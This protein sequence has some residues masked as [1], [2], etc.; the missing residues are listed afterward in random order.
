MPSHTD[1]TMKRVKARGSLIALVF[2][3]GFL[4]I[5]LQAVSLQVFKQ[6]GL[7]RKAEVRFGRSDTVTGKRGTI[8]DRH[9]RPLAVSIA[10]KAIGVYPRKAA[11]IKNVP[12]AARQIASL[13][14]ID[15]RKVERALQHPKYNWIKRPVPP[16]MGAAVAALKIPGVEVHPFH[17]RV[18]PSME[19]AGQ[20]IGASK[21]DD[22]GGR[23]GLEYRYNDILSPTTANRTVKWDGN[24]NPVDVSS[25]PLDEIS[26]SNLVLTIDANIQDIAESALK[27][28]AVTHK[29]SS[30][31]AVVMR[32]KTGEILAMAN[33]P[34]FNPNNFG[35]FSGET[36][37]NRAVAAGF[38][39]GSTMKVF[40]VAS[41]LDS[42][43][44]KQSSIFYCENGAYDIGGFTF[45]D[46]HEYEWLTLEQVIKFSSNIAVVKI[47]EIIG[48]KALHNALKDFGFGQRSGINLN[49]ESK[50]ILT[51]PSNWNMVETGAIAFGQGV[52]VT[53]LQLAT[54][55][56][57][58]ANDGMLV[59]P[60]IVKEVVS[61][62]GEREKTFSS[63]GEKRVISPETARFVKK[64]MAS[65]TEEG[66]TGVRA[67][68]S[69]YTV[70]GKTGTAQKI[71]P[72]KRYFKDRYIASFAGFVPMN[73]PE[74]SI[75]VV[76]DDPRSGGYYG[77]TVAGPAF[78][79][80]AYKTLD[81][82]H[83]A[84][85]NESI[86]EKLLLALKSEEKK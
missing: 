48:K 20:L 80:I 56:S 53:A 36:R 33:Y 73:N 52:S 70:C 55:Y 62:N 81:Y 15:A 34:G 28:A 4:V 32:P 26:G 46:T 50:G 24:G 76:L 6:G 64:I 54:A 10:A 22:I 58:L 30:G 84:P 23:N 13:L 74:L 61:P 41:A 29:A 79:E 3:M 68:L 72:N 78:R 35:A 18:Y 49:G 1:N 45:H 57:A 27:E 25:A 66:G 12:K 19:L 2:A 60:W 85:E 43:K 77:A 65:V 11:T 16:E 69:D 63:P 40:V 42:G 38:E 5:A 82:L 39:P 47:S 75:V 7:S 31:M 71:G 21:I 67:A 59:K 51:S 37:S 17:K 9:G 14:K 44:V 83:V 8:S 86:P